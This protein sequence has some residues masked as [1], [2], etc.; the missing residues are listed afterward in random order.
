[1]SLKY[2]AKTKGEIPPSINPFTWNGRGGWTLDV[3]GALAESDFPVLHTPAVTLV[4]QLR[5]GLFRHSTLVN[6]SSLAPSVKNAGA[7]ACSRLS[8]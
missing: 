2:R 3:A 1:M 8:A 7:P 6:A 5:D 4:N